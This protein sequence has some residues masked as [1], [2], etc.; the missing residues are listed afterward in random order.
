MLRSSEIFVIIE[1]LFLNL[2]F[3]SAPSAFEVVLC[4]IFLFLLKGCKSVTTE[5]DSTFFFSFALL[6][7]LRHRR[8][9]L[10][11]FSFDMFSCCAPEF[12]HTELCLTFS[13]KRCT[14]QCCSCFCVIFLVEVSLL[15]F[16]SSLF[17]FNNLICALLLAKKLI[18]GKIQYL[19]FKELN[20]GLNK[21]EYNLI[22]TQNDFVLVNLDDGLINL[23]IF[24]QRSGSF[25]VL[26]RKKGLVKNLKL[27]L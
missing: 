20:I 16:K 3:V 8:A 15:K 5:P 21:E 4:V 2:V 1:L 14:A 10:L 25:T 11:L 22:K 26:C 12:N 19:K 6:L 9:V 18:C 7:V 24:F 23:I 13:A 27:F 17:S